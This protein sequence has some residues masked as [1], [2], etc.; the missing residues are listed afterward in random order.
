MTGWTPTQR[1]L[2]RKVFDPGATR[3]EAS[4][5]KGAIRSDQPLRMGWC[6]LPC[7]MRTYEHR[8]KGMNT[9]LFRAAH[10]L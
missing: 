2:I 9:H 5:Q 1:G 10:T 8:I 7:A 6:A 3:E 4:Q